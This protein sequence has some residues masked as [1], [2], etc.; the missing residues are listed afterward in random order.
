[1]TRPT[2][3]ILDYGEVLS[4]PMRPGGMSLLASQLGVPESE[5]TQVYWR[6]RRDYDLGLPAPDYWT[7]VAQELGATLD[8]GLL[9]SLITVDVDSWTDYRDEMWTLAETFRQAGGR[10]ALLSNGVPEIVARIRSDRPRS[11]TRRSS[12]LKSV[13]PSPSRRSTASRSSNSAPLRPRPCLSTTG[14]RTS[15]PRANW[16]SKPPT[17]PATSTTSGG[18]CSDRQVRLKADATTVQRRLTATPSLCAHPREPRNAPPRSNRRER[19]P[20]SERS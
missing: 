16:A 18:S 10:L 15:R 19:T 3:L 9:A 20:A 13:S 14:S 2:A 12:R 5:M 8:D 7:L 17:S 4:H 11:S 6:H 1:V